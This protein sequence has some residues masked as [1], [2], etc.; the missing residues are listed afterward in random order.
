MNPAVANSPQL[1]RPTTGSWAATRSA[2]EQA[3][4][5]MNIARWEVLDEVGRWPIE[6]I[7]AQPGHD[8]LASTL[9]PL[10]HAAFELIPVAVGVDAA[11]IAKAL[12]L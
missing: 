4:A 1:R 12:G 3:K 6:V 5:R 2:L 10:G 9:K 7:D 8:V 11:T